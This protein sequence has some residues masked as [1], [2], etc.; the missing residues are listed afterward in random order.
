MPIDFLHLVLAFLVLLLPLALVY[1]LIEW[2]ERSRRRPA[3]P[4]S[5]PSRRRS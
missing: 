5:A 3:R 2:G 1:L 4:E